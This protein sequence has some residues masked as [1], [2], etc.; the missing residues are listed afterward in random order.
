[1][2]MAVYNGVV[3]QKVGDA[4]H[5]VAGAH[6]EVRSEIPGLPLA[7]LKSDRAG[8]TG[9]ANPFDA[10]ASGAFSFY[11]AG[12]PHQIRAYTG[13]SEDPTFEVF[14]NHVAIGLNAESDSIAQRSQI[15]IT[16]A[17][18]YVMSATDPDDIIFNKT[19]GA[20]TLFTLCD[21]ALRTSSVKIVDGKGDANTNNITIA[22]PAGKYLYGVL[23]G[24]TT[25]DGN[26]GSVQLTPR[27]D[28]TGWF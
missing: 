8:T 7:A 12:G 20:A 13:T 6:I 16:T 21:P 1:M 5:L 3:L 25:I 4:A 18:D 26:G 14:L 22:V 17:G 24:T 19:A 15:V 10:D 9:K 28:G 27:A 23:N 11:A 2:T